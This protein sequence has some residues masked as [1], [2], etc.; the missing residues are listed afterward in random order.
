MGIDANNEAAA[1]T[2]ITIDLNDLLDSG[3]P[4]FN[5]PLLGGDVVSIPRA[6]VI[7]AVGAVKSPGGFVMQ[8]ERQDM[9]ILKILALSGGLQPTAKPEQAVII[10]RNTAGAEQQ[11]VHV[12]LRKILALKSEDVALRQSDIL[13]VPDS[14]SKHAWRKTGEIAIALA[15]GAAII[16]AGRL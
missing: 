1:A 15:T 3:D 9:T 13:F 4:Q 6:G 5:I 12:D 14:T 11:E 16:N 2:T 8:A 10:R 7:Y